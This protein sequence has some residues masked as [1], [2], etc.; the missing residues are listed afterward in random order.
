MHEE[1]KRAYSHS[2]YLLDEKSF[3]VAKMREKLSGKYAP[4]TV[5]TVINRLISDGFL[6]DKKYAAHAAEYMAEVK[7][8]GAYRIRQELLS[9]GIDKE[10][11]A[12]AVTPFEIADTDVIKE[13][14]RKKYAA[15][16]GSPAGERKIQAAM[17]RYGF[18]FS[19]VMKALKS[20]KEDVKSKA[21]TAAESEEFALR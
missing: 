9:K 6:N 12:E 15:C 18:K 19:D 1:V 16:I 11:A 2:L 8:F 10:T 4:E 14:I 21:E 5:E 17:A 3:S 7:K 20:L 13:R